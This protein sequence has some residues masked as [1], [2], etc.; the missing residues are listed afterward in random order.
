MKYLVFILLF[1]LPLSGSK[2]ERDLVTDCKLTPCTMEF[3]TISISIK[4]SSDNKAVTLTS[5]KVIRVSDNVEITPGDND[6]TDNS[7]YY[8]LVN[9][10]ST[11]ILRWKKVGI[12]FRGYIGENLVINKLYVVSADCCHVILVSGDTEVLI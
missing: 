2:C 1:L 12:E 7:G 9:D 6:L 11:E 10:N 5:Y 3:R 4:K 8:S